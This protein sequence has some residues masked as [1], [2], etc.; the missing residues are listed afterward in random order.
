MISL[1]SLLF[2]NITYDG[3]FKHFV[4][5]FVFIFVSVFVFVIVIV[6][7]DVLL[8]PMMFNMWGLS[9][10]DLKALCWKC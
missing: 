7:A 5:V 8:F 2:E 1:S 4:F 3:S 6:V 10:D 9:C